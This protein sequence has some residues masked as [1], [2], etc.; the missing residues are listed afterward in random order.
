LILLVA[1]AAAVAGLTACSSSPKP[2]SLWEKWHGKVHDQREAARN[3]CQESVSSAFCVK[4]IEDL[5][6]TLSGLRGD[7]DTASR[8]HRGTYAALLSALDK[9]DSSR[10]EYVHA[11]C[12]DAGGITP[13]CLYAATNFQV[14]VDGVVLEMS[15]LD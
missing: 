15:K 9:A 5:A 12:E 8:S 14:Y 3:D 2:P 6:A 10:L 4:D 13:N 11:G 1:G 7:A